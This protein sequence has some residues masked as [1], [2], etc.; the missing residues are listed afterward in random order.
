MTIE[1][2]FMDAFRPAMHAH[3]RAD[4]SQA[5]TDGKGKLH[6]AYSTIKRPPTEQDVARH[7]KG[8]M[9]LLLILV[10]SEGK[11]SA[12]VIDIDD[13]KHDFRALQKKIDALGL[14]CV[15]ALTKSNGRHLWFFWDTPQ[16]ANAVREWLIHQV[17]A[18]DLSH[19]TEIFPKQDVATEDNP[20]NGINLPY[21]GA[22]RPAFDAA[23]RALTLQEFLAQVE[24]VR[25]ASVPSLTPDALET[26]AAGVEAA[27]QAFLPY[28]VD[29]NR[30][31]LSYALQGFLARKD[32]HETGDAIVARL[33]ELGGGTNIV[34][35]QEAQKRIDKGQNVPGLPKLIEASSQEAVAAMQRAL[36]IE[37]R[38]EKPLELPFPIG[39][40]GLDRLREQLPPVAFVIEKVLVAGKLNGLIAE[41][42]AGKSSL[43]LR[44]AVAVAIEEDFF[45]LTV[46]P[47]GVAYLALEDSADTVQR[48]VQTAWRN[49]SVRMANAGLSRA[50]IGAKE[51]A[52]AE[53]LYVAV[54]QGAPMHLVEGG[55]GGGGAPTAMIDA[56]IRSLAPA[57]DLR[58]VIVDP[59]VRTTTANENDNV[60]AAAVVTAM[61]RII[62]ATG[63]TVLLIHHVG[64]AAAGARQA[65]HYAGRGASALPDGMRNILRLMVVSE[66]DK[67]IEQ[68]TNLP[69]EDLLLGNVL[70]LVHAKINDGPKHRTM[71]LRRDGTDFAL[72]Q[73]EANPEMAKLRDIDKIYG[74]W[75]SENASADFSIAEAEKAAKTIRMSQDRVRSA[76]KTAQASGDIV[77]G[78]KQPHARVARL[79]FSTTFE[80]PHER[81]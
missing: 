14:Q 35:A 42:G 54:A 67:D 20:G 36:G 45:G 11:C 28:W 68:F 59:L 31:N 29:G 76:I 43:A 18:L 10:N 73:P 41:S 21:F 52:L 70:R 12:G 58:L 8:E 81:M 37:V 78:D 32:Q 79:R 77:E 53:R 17:M 60:A 72:I 2:Q 9:G 7:L 80:A 15:S 13:Y 6:P 63:A 47:G 25:M 62:A 50:E 75:K 71:Y 30:N 26:D 27:A 64:K 61:E 57:V 22:Q 66:G 46:M 34:T 24:A 49:A 44:M 48:R 51:K 55:A 33:K 1:Q 56:L 38:K 69:E 4:F 3:C 65:D 23:G 74:W 16:D 5:T 40:F 19:K 39:P